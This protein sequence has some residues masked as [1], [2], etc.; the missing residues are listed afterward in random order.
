[1]RYTKP[2]LIFAVFTVLL[3]T[4]AA[5]AK[6]IPFFLPYPY[7]DAG[8]WYLSEGWVNGPHQSCEWR[9]DAVSAADGHLKMTLSDRG[10][11][12]RPI[13]CP[14]MHTVTPTGYGIYETRM[15]TAAGSGL[16]TNMF[17]YIGPP[18]GGR[19]HDEIDFEFLGKDPHTVQLNYW[20]AG[21]GGHEYIDQL[22]FDA[23]AAFH[24]YSFDWEK[25]KIA[26]YVDGKKVHETAA[27]ATD[28][29]VT[30]QRIYVS[31]WS[32]SAIEDSWLGL[33]TYSKPV[34]AEVEW[35]KFTPTDGEGHPQP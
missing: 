14:E 30:P 21:K 5:Y 12:I 7:I 32:G 1:M 22:G 11:K 13:G 20:T 33:F 24:D 3:L 35:V 25:D 18:T 4:T 2:I 31:L 15:K 10:G 23:A 26:W 27:G 34:T 28:L 17:T 16:N 9:K 29:P 19:Q 8:H 6:E